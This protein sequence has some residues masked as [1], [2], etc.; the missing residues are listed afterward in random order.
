M[1]S[2]ERFTKKEHLLKTKDF[3]KAY[4]KGRSFR[5]ANIVLYCLPNTLKFNRLGFSISS[6]TVKHATA[7][8]RIRRL[9]REAYRTGKKEL[10][11]GFDLIVVV[12]KSVQVKASYGEAREML[13][14]LLKSAGV[15]S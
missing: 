11:S 7:R 12:K 14:G 9:L 3:A 6:K 8:N 13:L 1:I 15:S 10:K 2:D 4:K 5:C